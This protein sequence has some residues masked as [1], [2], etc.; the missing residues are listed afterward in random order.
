MADPKAVR[1][2]GGQWR[3]PDIRPTTRWLN[4][5]ARM[6]N[7]ASPQLAANGLAKRYPALP[8]D[9][10]AWE[11]PP[12]TTGPDDWRSAPRLRLSWCNRCL[13]EDFA[14]R[15]PAHI[16]HHWVLGASCFCHHHRWPLEER[17]SACDSFNWQIAGSPRGPLRMFCA[18]CW[19]PLEQSL[20]AVLSVEDDVRN[21]WDLVIAFETE[22]LTALSG[23]TPDQ[24]RFNFTS[25]HQLL[26]QV[27]DICCLLARNHCGYTRTNIPLNAFVSTA[28]APGR[29]RPEFLESEAPFPL[30]VASV[31]KRRCL[32]AAA[33]AI[34]DS[35]VETGNALFGASAPPALETFLATVD[36]DAIDRCLAAGGR[37]SPTFVRQIETTR[38]HVRQRTIIEKLEASISDC[39]N[40]IAA[41]R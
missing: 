17:C 4:G 14:A 2:R 19:R 39:D 8:L 9:F 15:R 1:D 24:F 36:G 23:R 16:R 11:W 26:N 27:R 29:L 3:H 37:W 31:S 38:R 34:L 28:M 18:E 12:F 22:V 13:A 21:C 10:L 30:A 25:A 7:V 40:A 35:R 6:F 41:A 32:L 20:P 5:A 33:C